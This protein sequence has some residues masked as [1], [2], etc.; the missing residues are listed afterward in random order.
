MSPGLGLLIFFIFFLNNK[1]K[2]G[3]L[4]HTKSEMNKPQAEGSASLSAS[5]SQVLSTLGQ[6]ICQWI[7][8]KTKQLYI[9]NL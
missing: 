6:E 4:F 9:K 3:V 7:I 8:G 5:H 2:N 1:N